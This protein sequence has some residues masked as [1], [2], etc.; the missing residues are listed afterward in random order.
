MKA[1]D[2]TF[3]LVRVKGLNSLKLEPSRYREMNREFCDYTGS[4]TSLEV[5]R[6]WLKECI[7]LHPVCQKNF[8]YQKQQL[9]TRLI[10]VNTLGESH[11]PLYIPT[12]SAEVGSY[13]TLSHRWGGANIYKLTQKTYKALKAGIPVELLPKTFRDAIHVTRYL[14]VRY[15][16]I[17]SLCIFQDSLEDWANESQHMGTIYANCLCNIAS[18]SAE[19]SGKGLFNSRDPNLQRPI[20]NADPLRPIPSYECW[21][22]KYWEEQVEKATL[23]SRG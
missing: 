23:N 18:T 12:N 2:G 3:R 8:R 15:I 16:W 4:S 5:A 14:E 1:K 22:S 6:N 11:V 10:D 7:T 17:D 13:V 9:P 20:C 19:H 21:P